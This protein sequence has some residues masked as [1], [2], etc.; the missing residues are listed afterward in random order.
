M[1]HLLKDSQ[2]SCQ[3]LKKEMLRLEH[4][5]NMLKVD[6]ENELAQASTR[7]DEAVKKAEYERDAKIEETR[8]HQKMRARTEILEQEVAEWQQARNLV[9]D[10]LDRERR[11]SEQAIAVMREEVT[12]VQTKRARNVEKTYAQVLQ[13][14]AATDHLSDLLELGPEPKDL[15]KY[16][17]QTMQ[18]AVYHLQR[19]LHSKMPKDSEGLDTSRDEGSSLIPMDFDATK[20]ETRALNFKKFRK[21]TT[22][23]VTQVAKAQ[24]KA[25]DE[26]IEQ[27][28]TKIKG[29]EGRL[30]ATKDCDLAKEKAEQREQHR[31]QGELFAAQDRVHALEQEVR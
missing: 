2:T 5:N 25:K 19:T 22:E 15:K 26:V 4:E 14:K 3:R 6:R 17:E 1:K 28:Q 11:R 20:L 29:L 18:E 23:T 16:V 27:L 10:E 31:M 12:K 9:Q 24:M 21:V 30:E 7:V 8:A 13:L